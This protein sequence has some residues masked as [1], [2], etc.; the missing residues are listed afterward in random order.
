M[1]NII[2]IFISDVILLL[3]VLVGLLIVRHES[4]IVFP[5]GNLLWN[6]V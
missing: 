3:T 4:G 6:Q 1:P 5:L 2:V